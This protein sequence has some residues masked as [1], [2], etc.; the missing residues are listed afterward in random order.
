V[1]DHVLDLSLHGEE[2][3]NEEVDQEDGPEDRHVKHREEGHRKPGDERLGHAVPELELRQASDE[4][5]VLVG[6]VDRQHG[7]VGVEVVRER[8]Q[9][10]DEQV[11]DEDPEAVGH[12]VKPLNEVDPARV[13]GDHSSQKHPS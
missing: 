13:R 12:D 7:A 10:S 3:E 2:E 6:L 4:G 1:L 5:L 9:E 8:G 11:E